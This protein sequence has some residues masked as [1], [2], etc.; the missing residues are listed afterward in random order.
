MASGR[1]IHF[2]SHHP[3]QQKKSIVFNLVDK[4]IQLSDVRFHNQNLDLVKK[5][6]LNN[7]YPIKLHINNRLKFLKQNSDTTQNSV[8]FDNNFIPLPYHKYFTPGIMYIFRRFGIRVVFRNI[9]KL[10]QFQ[11]LGKDK[12]S[13]YEKTGVI[14]VSY[15][16]LTLPTIYSV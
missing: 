13:K 12:L 6:L 9:N 7:G 10:D 4:A 5:L 1:Y 15:T 2:D 8:D 11:T 3:V 14:S 16:H